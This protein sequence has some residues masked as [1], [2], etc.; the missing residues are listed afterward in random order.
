M[1]LPRGIRYVTCRNGHTLSD[2][3]TYIRPDNGRR[4]CR[5]CRKTRSRAWYERK[6]ARA[7]QREAPR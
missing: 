1:P 2:R 7:E 4:E 3:T 5:E 6:K